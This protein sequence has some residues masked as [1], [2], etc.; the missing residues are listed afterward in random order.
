M[1]YQE[2]KSPVKKLIKTLET[3]GSGD[4]NKLLRKK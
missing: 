3:L 4:E 1:Q 2:Y